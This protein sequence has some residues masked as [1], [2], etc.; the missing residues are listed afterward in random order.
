MKLLK[1]LVVVLAIATAG[2]VAL[3]IV[4]PNLLSS[5]DVQGFIS[6]PAESLQNLADKGTSKITEAAGKAVEKAG[7]EAV[8]KMVDQSGLK[9]AAAAELH[10]RAGDIAALSG[11]DESMVDYVIDSMDIPSWQTTTL[12]DGLG[13]QAS[14]PVEYSGANATLTTYNDP[15][16]MTVS[17]YGQDITFAVPDAAQGY[18]PYLAYL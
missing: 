1:G 9:E 4:A 5:V 8:S 2:A 18:I 15:S 16:Y 17:A 13:E 7:N 10:A 3:S 6:S 12:P 11:L 14:I